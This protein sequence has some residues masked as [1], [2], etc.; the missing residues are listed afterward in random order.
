M[1]D[2][3]TMS[4]TRS[5]DGISPASYQGGGGC[6]TSTTTTTTSTHHHHHPHQFHHYNQQNNSRSKSYHYHHQYHHQHQQQGGA[7]QSPPLAPALLPPPPPHAAPPGFLYQHHLSGTPPHFTSYS[8]GAILSTRQNNHQNVEESHSPLP[9]P[10]PPPR[11]WLQV[12]HSKRK[13]TSFTVLC[14][15]ILCSR[16]ATKTL[17]NYC[18]SWALDWNYR[19]KAILSELLHYS[20]DI[21]SLQ[22]LETDQFYNFFLPQLQLVGYSGIFGAKTRA[23]TMSESKRRMVD[24]CAIFYRT[25]KFRLV[26]EH[27]IEFS[28]V[29]IGM[30]N[31]EVKEGR[32]KGGCQEEM[33]NRVQTKDNIAL[34][35]LFETKLDSEQSS[36]FHGLVAPR[37]RPLLVCTCHIHWDPNYCDVKLVQ[38]M[39]LMEELSKITDNL[40]LEPENQSQLAPPSSCS[41]SSSTSCSPSVSTSTSTSTSATSLE[42]KVNLLICGDFNSL[43]SSG[44]FQFMESGCISNH[45]PDFKGLSYQS[46]LKNSSDSSFQH[47][48]HLKSVYPPSSLPF[49]NYTLD[50]QGV[51]D[52]IFHSVKGLRPLGFL[53]P[54]DSSWLVQHNVVG[55]PHPSIPSDHLPLLVELEMMLPQITTAI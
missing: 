53:G 7:Y 26:S 37:P 29:A 11:P 42:S 41:S 30:A 54:L 22:E 15:N 23:R 31:R 40:I 48:F 34:A 18:P 5:R 49:T 6:T 52:Y 17:Y 38:S 28:Q 8:S 19:R 32:S 46:Y 4:R 12:A 14:Y 39:M 45:H 47:K 51:I 27:L 36:G 9:T 21:I 44:V 2:C 10:L 1:A 25:N 50:F 24:G 55:A 3:K 43:P 33:L 16:Y 35:A 13:R 20:P